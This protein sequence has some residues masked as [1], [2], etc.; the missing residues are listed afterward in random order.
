MLNITSREHG[1]ITVIDIE[2]SID[3]ES[4]NAINHMTVENHAD[5][6]SNLL[7][8]FKKVDSLSSSGVAIL[9]DAFKKLNS[10][11]RI[12]KLANV[13]PAILDVFQVH[14]VLPIFSIHAD[15]DS[16]MRQ[17]NID[18][19][20]SDKVYVRLFERINVELKA[21][22]KR[23]KKD[24]PTTMFPM[25]DAMVQVISQGGVFLRTT[26][27]YPDDT[28]LEVKVRLPESVQNPVVRFLA[29]VVWISYESV[30]P[31]LYL[32]M[33]LSI[34]FMEK[35]DQK[36]LEEFCVRTHSL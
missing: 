34:L 18:R 3:I 14:M 25:H 17:F 1:N 21:K 11:G 5:E 20:E 15:E 10:A 30:E 24:A 19:K 13:G 6:E 26:N 7:L 29:K 22:F 2:G 4:E 31:P 12:A 35:N 33:A 32:G 28:I 8:N 9:V 23:F 16:A 27:S 36:K